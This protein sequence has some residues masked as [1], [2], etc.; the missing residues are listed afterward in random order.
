M[1]DVTFYL[2]ELYPFCKQALG[3]ERDATVV[4]ESDFKNAKNPLGKTAYYDP[5]NHS[6]SVYVDGRHSKDIMRSVTHELVHH[7]QN[8]RGD[9]QGAS[10][11][12]GYAQNDE[13]L[14]EMEREAYEKGNLLF[15]DWEDHK[16]SG[17]SD[18][19]LM[20]RIME[21]WGYN[22]DPLHE[23][24]G[25]FEKGQLVTV[26]TG[27]ITTDGKKKGTVTEF[28]A[29][30]KDGN[31][32]PKMV[33]IK[34][35][36]DEGG[37]WAGK[38]VA[39]NPD[40]VVARVESGFAPEMG[41]PKEKTLGEDMYDEDEFDMGELE[42]EFPW[43]AKDVK[44]GEVPPE[45]A[46]EI[47]AEF[48][49][50]E[51]E[52]LTVM[53]EDWEEQ[54]QARA[55]A[56]ARK[57]G[58]WEASEAKE[59]A[60][61]AKK[62]GLQRLNAARGAIDN[63]SFDKVIAHFKK[64]GWDADAEDLQAI[65]DLA[66]EELYGERT[67]PGEEA[68]TAASEGLRDKAQ[69][70]DTAVRDAIPQAIWDWLVK[71]EDIQLD[72]AVP[73]IQGREAAE[74]KID[75][76]IAQKSKVSWTPEELFNFLEKSPGGVTAAD[77]KYAFGGAV[78][79]HTGALQQLVKQGK[80]AVDGG[81]Y[82]LAS[83]SSLEEMIRRAIRTALKEG[84][85]D[86]PAYTLY[87]K[88]GTEKDITLTDDE[89]NELAVPDP[90]QNPDE[91]LIAVLSGTRPE[92]AQGL[93]DVERLTEE[94]VSKKDVVAQAWEKAGATSRD[95]SDDEANSVESFNSWRDAERL[96]Q[97][98]WEPAQSYRGGRVLAYH[99]QEGGKPVGKYYDVQGDMYVDDEEMDAI[100]PEA[101]VMKET[102]IENVNVGDAVDIIG[103]VLSGATGKVIEFTKTTTGV[104]AA[105]VELTSAVPKPN[106]VYGGVG[107]EVL[108]KPEHLAPPGYLQ[109]N[110]GLEES[111]TSREADK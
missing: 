53:R 84:S 91:A 14:R 62:V 68:P 89:W 79:A 32:V 105:V 23:E 48:G 42:Q 98:E 2:E 33:K 58:G 80:L 15:R 108:V 31:V 67:Q 16:K 88:D 92:L 55:E 7:H 103:S 54:E 81:K 75:A 20:A 11:E 99:R 44:A 9:L 28:P 19:S 13:H 83:E 93:E 52:D 71:E 65:A 97:N 49:D 74:K 35:D 3:F 4:F 26:V 59:E 109:G 101:V 46:A 96:R 34:I 36:E 77:M 57:Q 107:D 12:E 66:E 110:V 8:L 17:N 6:I 21:K 45:L 47:A 70:L 64:E 41:A 60:E 27:T 37:E 102:G 90:D 30:D 25:G 24:G 104:E 61:R 29:I 69:Y 56:E 94:K 50:E 100:L 5:A 95:I 43:L 18:D 51:E 63:G 106:Q 85:S 40:N 86:R 1:S 82:T 111:T 10:M 78:Q 72:E 22:K 38:E 87:Y 39:V 76:M 73:A